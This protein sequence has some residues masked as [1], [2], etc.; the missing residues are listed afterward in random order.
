MVAAESVSWV[1]D[2]KRKQ[3]NFYT[4]QFVDAMAP[5][6]FALTNPI[7]LKRTMDSQG[8]NL[9]RGFQNI[10]ADLGLG[11]ANLKHGW[12][13]RRPLSWAVT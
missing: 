6:N 4:R 5:T 9:A 12:S 1:D 8:E 11:K 13:T 7:I 10:L 2:N 3:F